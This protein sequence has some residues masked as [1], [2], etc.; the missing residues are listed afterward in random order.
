MRA[1]SIM[2]MVFMMSV[3]A[4]AQEGRKDYRV[5]EPGELAV[6]PVQFDGRLVEISGEV[7]SINA[8]RMN[9]DIF[10]IRAKVL[11]V[12]SLE[13][14][15]ESQRRSLA[16]EPIHRVSV[17]GRL[18]IKGGRTEIVADNVLPLAA[19]LIATR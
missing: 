8:D 19:T 17:F 4:V 13:K 14:L 9:M 18:E 1:I 6:N 2:V 5:V 12:V 11:I 10:D 16:R 3:A 15:S 7:V